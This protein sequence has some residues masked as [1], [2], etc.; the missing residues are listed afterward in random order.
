MKPRTAA[1]LIER[2]PT[3]HNLELC[4]NFEVNYQQ[5]LPDHRPGNETGFYRQIAGEI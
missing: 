4:D 3:K 5:N 1:T 2:W